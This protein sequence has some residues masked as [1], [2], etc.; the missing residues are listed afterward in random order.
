MAWI[1]PK[2]TWVNGE[3]FDVSD[4]NRIKGNV[5]ELK[6]LVTTLYHAYTG[7]D[8]PSVGYTAVPRVGFFE[9]IASAVTELRD[10]SIQVRQWQ[11]L[12]RTYNENG[13]AWD[14]TEINAI[15][16]NMDL[17]HTMLI[18]QANGL[19]KTPFRLGSARF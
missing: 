18:E 17:L 16:R 6:Q 1:T 4:Y 11:E 13:T 10:N 9:N 15:E 5:A 12:I 19:R 7:T 2:T 8:L 14:A 3:W